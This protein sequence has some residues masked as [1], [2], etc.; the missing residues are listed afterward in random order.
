M[1]IITENIIKIFFTFFNG[2]FYIIF[3]V[4]IR[5]DMFIKNNIPTYENLSDLD[6]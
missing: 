4:N 2:I 1:N 6:I 3:T 5:K